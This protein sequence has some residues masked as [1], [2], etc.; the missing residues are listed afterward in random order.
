MEHF[1][2]IKKGQKLLDQNSRLRTSIEELGLKL[3]NGADAEPQFEEIEE[4]G[5]EI[6]SPDYFN[7]AF[8]K[9]GFKVAQPIGIVNERVHTLFTVSGIQILDP[10]IHDG[11]EIS[12][13]KIFV[14]QPV[15]RTQFLPQV[16]EGS[17]TSFINLTAASI[18]ESYAEHF[19]TI[20]KW[21]AIMEE[22]GFS[23]EKISVR[24]SH[25][26][27]KWG[28]REFEN[29]FIG[30][31][32]NNVEIGEASY[33]EKMP[34]N[35]RPSISI[36]EVAFGKERM[37]FSLGGKTFGDYLMQ[38]A[39]I[40]IIDSARTLTLLAGSGVKPGNRGREYRTRLFSKNFVRENMNAGVSPEDI[41]KLS[42]DRWLKWIKLPLNLERTID[43]LLTEYDR[44]FNRETLNFLA[45]NKVNIEMNVNQPTERF[46]KQLNK[47]G[48]VDTRLIDNIYKLYARKKS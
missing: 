47:T 1:E 35:N 42:Y 11:A 27:N 23:K 7:E 37:N 31:Y 12:D 20:K 34:Q 28:K 46:M 19:F 4:E 33:I 38:G 8:K 6:D 18:N 25:N 43:I 32:Y 3:M 21:L 24:V 22:M 44:N 36:S 45:L 39:S 26:K 16:E 17:L 30:I 5:F 41:F 10:I 48:S 2:T 9:E 14:A 29:E 15:I 13:Q 40:K